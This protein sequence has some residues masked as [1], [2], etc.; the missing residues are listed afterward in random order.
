MRKTIALCRDFA[1]RRI[2]FG[3]KVNELPLSITVLHDMEI[4]YRGNLLFYLSMSQMLSFIEAGES[5]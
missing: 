4:T 2:V 1:N 5:T 3:K